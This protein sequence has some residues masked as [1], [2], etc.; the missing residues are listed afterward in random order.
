[1]PERSWGWKVNSSATAGF[2]LDALEQAIHAR[3]PFADDGLIHHSDRGV[4]YLA[5]NCTQRLADTNFVRSVGSD[6]DSH[7]NALAETINASTWPGSSGGSGHDR[8]RQR[9]K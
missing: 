6:G 9:W 4:Q 8:A 5:M 2:A 7:D 1:M 3:R